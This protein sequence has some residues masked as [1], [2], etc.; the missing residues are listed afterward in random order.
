MSSSLLND[1]YTKFIYLASDLEYTLE[2][3]IQK[4]KHKLISYLQDWPNSE[5]KLFDLILALAKH[6]LFIYKHMQAIDRDQNRT[7]PQSTTSIQ[8][9]IRSVAKF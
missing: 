5:V 7:K 3:F 1:F 8:A 6:C 9:S 4:F 2:M